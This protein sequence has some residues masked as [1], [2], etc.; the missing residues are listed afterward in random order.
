MAESHG[1]V[2]PPK[3]DGFAQLKFWEQCGRLSLSIWECPSFLFIVMGLVT[4]GSMIGT[5]TIANRYTNPDIVI[6]VVSLV[7]MVVFGIGFVVVQSFERVAYASMMRMEFVSIASHQLRTPLAATRWTLDLLGGARLGPLTPKQK[8]Y[9]DILYHSNRRMIDLVNDLLDVS[10]IEAGRIAFKRDPVD[11]TRMARDTAEALHPQAEQKGV[12]IQVEDSR[13][14]TVQADVRYSKMVLDNLVDNAIHYNKQKGSIRIKVFQEGKQG[15][16]EVVDT[17]EGIP[18]ADQ[19]FIF[20]KFFRANTEVTKDH[21]G[22]T[23]LGLF[24]AR[25]VVRGMGGNIGFTSQEG[26]G[27]TFWF[28]LPLA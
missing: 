9:F 10:R 6:A 20:R 1:F 25:S 27:S 18:A 15:R 26:K 16:V 17:G 5:Y 7:A 12:V 8:E 19:R 11:L 23:G 3:S 4:I 14:L 2:P 22:G 13:A 24:I 28:E 21:R